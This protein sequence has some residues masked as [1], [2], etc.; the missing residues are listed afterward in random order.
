MMEGSR[1]GRECGK[2]GSVRPMWRSHSGGGVGGGGL[3]GC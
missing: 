3:E 2:G 1:L